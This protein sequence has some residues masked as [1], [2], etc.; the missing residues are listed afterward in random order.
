MLGEAPH[1][2]FCLAHAFHA[3]IGAMNDVDTVG[4]VMKF[5]SGAI[6][7]ID[8]SR[9]AVY[10]Y[11]QRVEVFGSG[12]MLTSDNQSSLCATYFHA[13][14]ST[15][16]PIKVSFPQRYSE[17]YELEMNHFIDV[18]KRKDDLLISKD[19]VLRSFTVVEAIEKSFQTGQPVSLW[20]EM[21]DKKWN[22]KYG[23]YWWFLAIYSENFK[24]LILLIF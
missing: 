15:Q 11:D 9:H 8:L 24:R 2:V 17:A 4:V 5:P 3:H 12:G 6:G 18:I 22:L 7:Q 21:I 10:G 20:K 19:D 16:N 14:G 13:S 23:N 1:T